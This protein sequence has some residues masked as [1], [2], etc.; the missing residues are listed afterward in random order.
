MVKWGSV[1]GALR[2]M[3]LESVPNLL[4]D[5]FVGAMVTQGAHVIGQSALANGA[6][7]SGMLWGSFTA[8][9]VDG[10]IRQAQIVAIL[11]AV[12]T[13]FGIIHDSALHWP[14]LDN[15]I[16]WGYVL[17]AVILWVAARQPLE[18]EG[19]EL[20]ELEDLMPA[21]ETPDT[22]DTANVRQS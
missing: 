1:L 16:V 2:D 22:T 12:M 6:I 10:K 4:D 13:A 21:R 14:Q 15:H 17:L 20:M 18:R 19:S 9:L 7:V 5:S 8:F 11:A 3:G